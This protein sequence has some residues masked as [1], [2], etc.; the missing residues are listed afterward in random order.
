MAAAVAVFLSRCSQLDACLH[1]ASFLVNL[2]S[3]SLVASVYRCAATACQSSAPSAC[4]L[5][6]IP[7][8][9]SLSIRT[10]SSPLTF[11]PTPLPVQ[12]CSDRLLTS[13][14][15]IEAFLLDG[16]CVRRWAAKKLSVS[17]GRLSSW[18]GRGLAALG[19]SPV[20]PKE[21]AKLRMLQL[22]FRALAQP[23]PAAAAFGAA[24]RAAAGQ[25]QQQ[26]QAAAATTELAEAERLA[27]CAHAAVWLASQPLAFD[28]PSGRFSSEQEWRTVAAKR[29]DAAGPP[30]L[31]LSDMLATLAA[32]GVPA[33]AY[34]A[35]STDRL[36]AALFTAG[37]AG[38]E[39]LHAKLAL[40]AYHLLD[41]GFMA[42]E[43]I[44]EGLK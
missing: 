14:D 9:A 26:Q 35:P 15:P 40:L 19:G 7:L 6:A 20:V 22:V 5:A 13:S 28:R 41:G 24:G 39:A 23:A 36:L 3:S 29:R 42:A 30:S 38:R 18:L 2:P 1:L 27:H 4:S 43:A 32:H 10:F 44:T 11:P 31:F 16:E 25:Q 17:Q 37:S 12:V 8:E 34:P 33:L 21:L